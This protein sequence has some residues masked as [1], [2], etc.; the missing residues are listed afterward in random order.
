M[1]DQSE[2]CTTELSGHALLDTPLLNKGTA[3]SQ[4]ERAELALTGLLPPHV[5][6]LEDQV[7]RAWQAYSMFE[8]D[9][10]KHIYLRALQDSNETLF[11]RLVQQ[12]VVEMM[13]VIYTPV[14]GLACQRFSEIYRRPRGLFIAYPERDRIDEILRN[15]GQPEVRVIVVTDGERILGLGD[16]GAGGLGIP[17][18]KLSLYTVCGGVDPA[19]ALP[20]VLDVGTNNAERLQD[21]LYIGWRNQ[22][23]AGE[24][25]DEFVDLFVQAVKRKWPRV[26]LQFEDFAQT[27]AGPLLQKYRD[28]LCCFNDDIQGTA[29]VCVGTL[30]AASRESGRRLC[31]QNIVFAGAGAA[32]CGIAD[33]LVR[34]M[35]RQGVDEALARSRVFMVDRD[36]LLHTDSSGLKDF[37]EKLAQPVE[38][39]HDWIDPVSAQVDLLAV[40][41]QVSPGILIGVS[42]QPG[43]FTEAV[44]RAMYRGCP[45][46][47]I[48]PLSNPTARIEAMPGDLL[49]WTEGRAVIATGS[50]F[51]DLDYDGRKIRIS[52]CNN[53]YIFPAVGLGVLAAGAR[54]VT[55]EMFM[56]ASEALSQCCDPQPDSGSGLLP[57]LEQIQ[58]LSREIAHQVALQAQRDGVAEPMPEPQLRATIDKIFWQPGYQP[59]Y[60]AAGGEPD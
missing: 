33:Q 57:P 12:Y 47:V 24:E 18:G 1:P 23:I 35:V 37:Q 51:E 5:E 10:E 19:L 50:P 25:Y 48:L 28:R 14:V 49:E 38:R 59:L 41:E 39:V 4:R 45:R 8:T 55:D 52:Q 43:L 22:R 16:Q 3:F 9:L 15:C 26:L 40:V 17:I 2:R 53:S 27:H 32:G 42:G 11:Y 6:T 36:G 31:D 46:P 13:P 44:V 60:K 56:A 30:L 29:A 20:V 7:C 34:A 58:S 54:Y 21:P